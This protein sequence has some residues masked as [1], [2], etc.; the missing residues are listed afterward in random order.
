[1]G[2]CINHPDIETKFECMK[3]TVFLCDECLEC[4]DPEL[5]CK[6]RSSCPIW[7]IYKKNKRRDKD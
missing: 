6:F 5:Y 4:R 1:M 2:K 3:Y 7:F